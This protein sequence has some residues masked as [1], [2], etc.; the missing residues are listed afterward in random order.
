[1][2][3]SVVKSEVIRSLTPSEGGV[4]TTAVAWGANLAEKALAIPIGVG[5]AARNEAFRA[6]YAGIDWVEGTNQAAFKIVRQLVQ[7]LDELSLEF[8]EGLESVASAGA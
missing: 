1:M 4:H 6:V 7:R 5:R 3:E 8:V 2:A